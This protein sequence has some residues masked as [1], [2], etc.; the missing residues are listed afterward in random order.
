M[1]CERNALGSPLHEMRT[2]CTRNCPT[3]VPSALLPRNTAPATPLG[4]IWLASKK[5]EFQPIH[6]MDMVQL[7]TAVSDVMLT[8]HGPT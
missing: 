5:V 4:A 7:Q 2:Y 1:K 6:I 8:P 3:A